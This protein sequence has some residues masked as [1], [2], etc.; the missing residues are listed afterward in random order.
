METKIDK[1][2]D[3]QIIIIYQK[4]RSFS[5]PGC[6]FRRQKQST[7]HIDTTMEVAGRCLQ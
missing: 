4:Q 3:I 6:A 1:Y 7:A 2:T 5:L